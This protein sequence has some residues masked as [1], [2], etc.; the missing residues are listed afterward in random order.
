[1][2]LEDEEYHLN[3]QRIAQILGDRAFYLECIAYFYLEEFGLEAW[4]RRT[5]L[6]PPEEPQGAMMAAAVAKFVRMTLRLHGHHPVLLNPLAEYLCRKLGYRP[7]Q[8][9]VYYTEEGKPRTLVFYPP[10]Q[11]G[12]DEHK[13]DL[14]DPA[15]TGTGVPEK[16]GRRLSVKDRRARRGDDAE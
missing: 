10:E 5:G 12:S 9:A 8:F 16:P 15:R 2:A 4:K 11:G 3:S 13:R 1:M 7:K 6:L 14:A